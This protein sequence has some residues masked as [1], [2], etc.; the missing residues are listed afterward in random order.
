LV[1]GAISLGAC[2][3]Q[4]EAGPVV[5]TVSSQRLIGSA[6]DAA[7]WITYSGTYD[8]KRHSS[9]SEIDKESVQR[10]HL[11]WTLRWDR[12]HP[13]ETT[14]L[15]VDGTM[16]ATRPP[17][18]V[19]AIDVE[20][21]NLLWELE[22]PLPSDMPTLCCGLVNRG[23][24]ML[25]ETLYLGT[26]DAHLVAIDS[27]TGNKRW[28]V[29]VGDHRQ[30]FNITAAPLAVKDMIIV[31]TSLG[32][33]EGEGAKVLEAIGVGANPWAG[34]MSADQ[35]RDFFTVLHEKRAT[36]FRAMGDRRGRID[37]Y[38][39]ATGERRWRFIT[40]PGPGEP[41]NE[42]WEG[43]SWRVGAASPWMTGSYEPESNLLYWGTGNPKPAL[44]DFLRK[45]DNLYSS[46]ML[47]LDADSGTLKW[48]FQFTSH[49]RFDWDAAQVPVLADMDFDGSLRKLL[50][51]ANRN[52]FF[53]TLDRQ[54]GELLGAWPFA[55]QTWSESRDASGRPVFKS[56]VE[57][58]IGGAQVSP[59]GGGGTSWYSPS[60]SPQTGLFYVTAH[61]AT[62]DFDLAE[63]DDPN[64]YDPELTSW[65]RAI[66]PR[67]GEIVWEF[68][69]PLRSTSG[70]LTTASGLLF[71]GSQE[72]DFWALDSSSGKTL[73]HE[74]VDGWVHSAA[75]T[76]ESSGRQLVSIASSAG[77]FTYGLER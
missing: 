1:L 31:G 51:T 38:D 52:A 33:V 71:V 34:K 44:T 62:G 77:I 70:I 65:V 41:G 67:S 50:L 32:S 16:Y 55:K 49:D 5:G 58:K 59:N 72:G 46:S 56:G 22:W 36:A 11:K 10:L 66:E 6:Q 21:G 37:A 17:N 28:T 68:R 48:H 74:R 2:E 40:V 43:E 8:G 75:I 24:A 64:I 61:D 35:L 54:T 26:L 30:G 14:P 42:T 53:Y 45:G 76:Y 20:T 18:D 23:L 12:P 63:L 4:Q 29:E 73:W 15:V 7:N 19:L 69:L 57:A 3:P 9:L 39:A 60:F 25:D 13:V 27:R 47:A